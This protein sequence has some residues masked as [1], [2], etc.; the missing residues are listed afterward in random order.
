MLERVRT[1]LDLLGYAMLFF[2]QSST[3]SSLAWLRLSAPGA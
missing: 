3:R 1:N 2:P